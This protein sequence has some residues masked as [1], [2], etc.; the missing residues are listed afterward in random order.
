MRNPGDAPLVQRGFLERSDAL[1]RQLHPDFG[2]TFRL[3]IVRARS[4]FNPPHPIPP[5][6][7]NSFF[8]LRFHFAVSS[9]PSECAVARRSSDVSHLLKAASCL[10]ECGTHAWAG[11]L[12]HK[13]RYNI[14]G[15]G[16]RDCNI[17]ANY[18]L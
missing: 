9:I 13:R 3:R 16:D 5:S 15:D 2:L 4:G 18:H 12:S 17:C 1:L 7:S 8:H 14:A 10:F 11:A 6:H